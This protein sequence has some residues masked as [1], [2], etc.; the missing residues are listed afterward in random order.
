MLARLEVQGE[1]QKLVVPEHNYLEQS[2]GPIRLSLGIVV[3]GPDGLPVDA[4]NLVPS[5]NPCPGGGGIGN[6]A[7]DFQSFHCGF[8]HRNIR[9]GVNYRMPSAEL[10]G[11]IDIL[12]IAD[13]L[14]EQDRGEALGAALEA[15]T[16]HIRREALDT[17]RPRAVDLRDARLQEQ[18]ESQFEDMTP[19]QQ[20]D[21]QEFLQRMAQAGPALEERVDTLRS[22]ALRSEFISEALSTEVVRT[23]PMFDRKQYTVAIDPTS[24]EVA[25]LDKNQKLL[26]LVSK[27]GV[28]GDL[29]QQDRAHVLE[30][31][32]RHLKAEHQL[33]ASVHRQVPRHKPSS[34]LWDILGEEDGDEE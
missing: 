33:W 17:L 18:M 27:G 30:E 4:D 3:H 34:T 15:F 24:R 14:P 11:A 10:E 7:L 22:E 1:L 28:I 16:T 20:Q 9:S 29:S 21:A 23:G 12:S 19:P 5:L 32:Y 13:T 26:A 2:V 31:A 6:Q 25:F 8:L